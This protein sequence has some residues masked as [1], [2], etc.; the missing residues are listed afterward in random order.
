MALNR[1]FG[2]VFDDTLQYVDKKPSAD[3][4]KQWLNNNDN[5]ALAAEMNGEVVGGLVAYTLHKFEQERSEVYIYDLAVAKLY[6]RHG[7]ATKLINAL[8][9]VAKKQGSYVIFVQAEEGESS[10]KFYESLQP[11]ENISARSFDI[12][13]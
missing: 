1:L 11:S 4:L 2:E 12:E 8:R 13:V 3:Y 6:H 5:I 10:V 7:I 9:H